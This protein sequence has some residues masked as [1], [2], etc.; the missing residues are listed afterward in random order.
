MPFF[1]TIP[2]TMINPMNDDRLN[3]VLVTSSA[4]KTPTVD[5]TADAITATGAAKLPNSN[6]STVKTSSTASTRT[7]RRS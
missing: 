2:I 5:S 4:K 7:T 1:A 6:N 3:V